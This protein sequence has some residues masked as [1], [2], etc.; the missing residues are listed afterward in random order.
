[1]SGETL[2]AVREDT[3]LVEGCTELESE[4]CHGF[5][6]CIVR[7]AAGVVAGVKPAALFN[8][9]VRSSCA[10]CGSK[11][12]RRTV[13]EVISTYAREL[14][15]YG[16]ELLVLFADERKVVLFAYRP[17][18]V[19][20]L[21]AGAEE[22]RFLR[23]AGYDTGSVHAVVYRLRR[24]MGAYYR[25]AHRGGERPGYPHEVGLLLG[26]PLEDVQGFMR[27]DAET[28]RG[29]WKAYG[30]RRAAQLLFGRLRKHERRCQA[31]YQGGSSFSD[32]FG[33]SLEGES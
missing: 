22:G 5:S 24:R 14:P 30:D 19:G 17:E 3:S 28:C 21:I 8:Y 6:D 18:L 33:S 23:E 16:V 12:L 20:A 4:I 1:M 13:G 32:L 15:R 31:L 25:A 7:R 27:G 11:A 10:R 29:P 9:V 26:Y 2:M